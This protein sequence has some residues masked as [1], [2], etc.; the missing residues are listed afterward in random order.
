MHETFLHDEV[1]N[2]AKPR[3]LT[4]NNVLSYIGLTLL[5]GLAMIGGMVHSWSF[6]SKQMVIET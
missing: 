5:A 2:I 3:L 1:V 6:L 4:G